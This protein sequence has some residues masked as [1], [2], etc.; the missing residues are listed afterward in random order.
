MID[1]STPI[2]TNIRMEGA[3]N[4]TAYT[5][6]E[7]FSAAG[8]VVKGTYQGGDRDGEEKILGRGGGDGGGLCQVPARDP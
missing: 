4:K 2:S 7:E 6:E 3:P 5:L 1:S 8:V